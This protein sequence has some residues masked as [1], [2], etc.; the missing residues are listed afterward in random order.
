MLSRAVE[1][2]TSKTDLRRFNQPLILVVREGRSVMLSRAAD[3]ALVAA[4]LFTGL[5]KPT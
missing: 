1:H 4:N 5:L 2:Y 3:F